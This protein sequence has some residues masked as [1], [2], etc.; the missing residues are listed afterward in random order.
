LVSE[1]STVYSNAVDLFMKMPPKARAAIYV[2]FYKITPYSR[3]VWEH[4]KISDHSQ[5]L[6]DEQTWRKSM[7]KAIQ[8][9]I[10]KIRG[11]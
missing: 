11:F 1:N 3:C 2:E 10:E 5:L 9:Y 4:T 8:K 6:L 7:A